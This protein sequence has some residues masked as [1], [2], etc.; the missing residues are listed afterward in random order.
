MIVNKWNRIEFHDQVINRTVGLF[1]R[2]DHSLGFA[3]RF[4]VGFGGNRVQLGLGD[5]STG[6]NR[7]EI[8]YGHDRQQGDVRVSE[9]DA[10]VAGE[11]NGEGDLVSGN[12]VVLS[13]GWLVDTHIHPQRRLGA[14][15]NAV[16]DGPGAVVVD[17]DGPTAHVIVFAAGREWQVYLEQLVGVGFGQ[18]HEIAE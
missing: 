2:H 15:R 1:E 3:E 7:V 12:E 11:G 14:R 9:R 18:R 8:G 13:P 17:D 16:V 4:A 5:H 6:E 10:I